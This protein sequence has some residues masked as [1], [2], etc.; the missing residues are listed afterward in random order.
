M[1]LLLKKMMRR[2]R[3]NTGNQ[4][5]DERARRHAERD[6]KQQQLTIAEAKRIEQRNRKRQ[7]WKGT[8]EHGTCEMAKRHKPQLGTTE[9][10]ENNK[11]NYGSSIDHS[12][13]PV[14]GMNSLHE[15]DANKSK[16]D[17]NTEIIENLSKV[18]EE[19]RDKV[20]KSATENQTESRARD[21]VSGLTSTS[22]F[23][24]VGYRSLT[25][26]IKKRWDLQKKSLMNSIQNIVEEPKWFGRFKFASKK[27]CCNLIID[28]LKL[29]KIACTK[30]MS[31]PEFIS[32]TSQK[33]I[34]MAFNGKRHNAESKMRS[35]YMSK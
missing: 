15:D 25:P 13:L 20:D 7:P 27:I 34:F 32:I 11:E 4:V 3:T 6:I 18:T 26:E 19:E 21:D 33:M 1:F 12:H 5:A 17:K 23:S 10:R 8:S 16:V 31:L 22:V 2:L 29:N 35:A 14:G 9:N 28:S 24:E 30:G